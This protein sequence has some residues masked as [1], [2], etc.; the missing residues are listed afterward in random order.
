M[1]PKRFAVAPLIA[2]SRVICIVGD[3]RVGSKSDASRRNRARRGISPLGCFIDRLFF[4]AH[5]ERFVCFVFVL[6]CFCFLYSLKSA[7]TFRT[8]SKRCASASRRCDSTPFFVSIRY[9]FIS[10]SLSLSLCVRLQKSAH[11]RHRH[12]KDEKDAEHS[13]YVSIQIRLTCQNLYLLLVRENR[14]TRMNR[15]TI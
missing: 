9:C 12:S 3:R 8:N 1:L 15:S 2:V 6:F 5:Y 4:F 13:T 10:L 14:K 7:W 11:E